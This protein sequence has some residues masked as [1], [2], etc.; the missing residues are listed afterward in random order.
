MTPLLFFGLSHHVCGKCH[1]QIVITDPIGQRWWTRAARRK[2]TYSILFCNTQHVL[3]F[4]S[5]VIIHRGSSFPHKIFGGKKKALDCTAAAS[6]VESR[7][8]SPKKHSI[9]QNDHVLHFP[10]PDRCRR[11]G[12]CYCCLH[13]SLL[14]RALYTEINRRNGPASNSNPFIFEECTR[15]AARGGGLP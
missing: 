3:F 12:Y 15:G 11:F 14:Y 10:V 13:H 7:S 5:R 2:R 8:V 6:A 9:H 4:H 1:L